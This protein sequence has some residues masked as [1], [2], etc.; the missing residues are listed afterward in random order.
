MWVWLVVS[1][2]CGVWCVV[3]VGILIAEWSRQHRKVV[4]TTVLLVVLWVRWKALRRIL[5]SWP[6]RL[7]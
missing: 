3:S 1:G 6:A 4:A 5:L 2:V 7:L